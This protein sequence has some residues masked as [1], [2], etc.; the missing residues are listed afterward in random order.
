MTL[1][2]DF[3]PQ[4]AFAFMLIFARIG[5]M[6]MALPGIGDHTVPPR[7]RLVFA[8]ALTLIL[9]PLVNTAFPDL[10]ETMNAMIASFVGEILVG[11]AIGFAVRMMINAV[12]FA[13]TVIAFQTGLAFAQSVDPTQGV[14]SSMFASFFSILSIA[15]IFATDLHHTLL[16]AMHDSYQ[17]FR[18]GSG[19]PA[20]DFAQVAVQTLANAFRVALRIAAPFLV[21]GLIFYLG[22]GILTRLIP[23]V[24]VFFLAM[25]ASIL[26]GLVLL[27]LLLSTLMYLF[28]DYFTLALEPYLA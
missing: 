28:I 19:L 3:L 10:P 6:A 25:P 22:V 27:M 15:L 23:Q 5:A 16:A 13:G 17:I 1:T 11:I 8:L 12:H 14:Q 20:G 2:L 24:Q 18:P 9:F 21:F 4:T 7:L 26:L